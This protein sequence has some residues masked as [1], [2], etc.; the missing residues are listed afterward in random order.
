MEIADMRVIFRS[1]ACPLAVLVGLSILASCGSVDP[2]LQSEIDAVWKRAAPEMLHENGPPAPWEV[3][4]WVQLRV[5]DAG[6][7]GVRTVKLADKEGSAW[8]LEV[9]D[10]WPEAETRALA[11][12]D[13]YRPEGLKDL[14]VLRIKV[15]RPD[16]EAVDLAD[17]S[18]DIPEAPAIR[19]RVEE[20]LDAVRHRG[21]TG[22]IHAVTVPAGTFKGALA[23]PIF[24]RRGGDTYE[25]FVWY[26][27]AVP[28]LGFAKVEARRP[29]LVFLSSTRTT[30]VVAFGV[31]PLPGGATTPQGRGSN[32]R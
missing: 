13:N 5:D 2:A 23:R 6:T 8:W 25:G 1:S 29:F 4:Q 30:E 19:A 18:A 27:N 3:G 32:G 28:L 16:G 20:L 17:A 21:T 14:K 7:L 22:N 24:S 26:T 12:V 15:R 11:L 9:H 31:E 10:V